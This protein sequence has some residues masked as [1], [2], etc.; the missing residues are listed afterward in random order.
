MDAPDTII[1]VDAGGTTYH[2][3]PQPVRISLS[4]GPPMLWGIQVHVLKDGA[5]LGIKTCFVG[6]ITLH[7]RAPDVLDGPLEGLLPVIHEVITEKIAARLEEG[8][9]TDEIVFA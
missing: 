1:P 7:S 8:E 9:V 6:R 2:L 3:A 5:L 4:D